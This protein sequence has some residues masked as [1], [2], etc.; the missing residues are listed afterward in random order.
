MNP[1]IILERSQY[2][3]RF[4]REQRQ[5]E[6]NADL[7]AAYY[8][9]DTIVAELQAEIEY[10]EHAAKEWLEQGEREAEISKF[11]REQY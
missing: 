7:E 1:K 11:N 3:L 5:F 9:A 6:L 2:I 4:L 8:A 10:K